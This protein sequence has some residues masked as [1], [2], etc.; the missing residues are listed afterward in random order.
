MLRT[1]T[2][3]PRS[4]SQLDPKTFAHVEYK[5]AA[6]GG[7]A[8]WPRIAPVE[9]HPQSQSSQD[10]WILRVPPEIASQIV[11]EVPLEDLNAFQAASPVLE[12]LVTRDVAWRLAGILQNTFDL[13]PALLL[14]AIG[15]CRAIIGGLLPLSLLDIRAHIPDQL[16]IFT[17]TGRIP[18]LNHCGS[19]Y[20]QISRLE[21]SDKICET[22]GYRDF[23]DSV[24]SV[25]TLVG[26]TSGK[27]I[28]I[29]ECSEPPVAV[30]T[31]VPSTLLMNFVSS[32]GVYSLY[33]W[34]TTL[35]I[36]YLTSPPK[37][38]TLIKNSKAPSTPPIPAVVELEAMGFTHPRFVAK[39]IGRH[40][41][42]IS[43]LCPLREGRFPS[44]SVTRVDLRRE[45]GIPVDESKAPEI[46]Y[47]RWELRS[48][49]CMSG[50]P[51]NGSHGSLR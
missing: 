5:A 16:T 26:V 2:L 40:W 49:G 1:T 50:V 25:T 17:H 44:R 8:F 23:G 34:Q 42:S 3:H 29:I 33:P 48:D 19:E 32:D 15:S 22:L 4:K 28:H 31:T 38:P 11:R 43:G 20:R 36:G 24:N 13:R 35:G 30:L 46:A 41:C 14:A 37:R 39:T 9:K 18:C 7:F 47:A 6:Q 21:D 51:R 12:R 27:K 45:L 10:P